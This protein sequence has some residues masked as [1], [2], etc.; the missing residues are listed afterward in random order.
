MK[1]NLITILSLAV[2]FITT[3]CSLD[4][5]LADRVAVGFDD[6]EGM[7][8][9][10]DG[11]YN[12]MSSASY[13]ARNQVLAGEIR[14]DNVFSN[15]NSGRFIRWST[16]NIQDTDSDVNGLMSVAYGS[17][18]N[19]NILINTNLEGI[20]GSDAEKNHVLGE[21]YMARAFV[22]FD[23]LRLFGQKYI[24]EGS[25][26]GVS[27]IKQY[28]G[29][30]DVP[31]GSVESNYED[32]KSDISEAI[33]YFELGQDSGFANNKTNFTLDAAY[34]LQSRI[35]IYM[36]DYPY[37]YAGSSQIVDAYDV[38]P[39]ADFVEMW[40]QQTPPA[41]S[42]FE[43]YQNTSTDN[44]GNSS[45]A[46]IYRGSSY[47]DV[48]A[49]DN[50]LEDAEFEVGNDVRAS[51]DMIDEAN[52]ALRNMGKYPSM[53]QDLGQDNIKVFRIEEVVLN[54]AEALANGAGSGDALEYLNRIPQNRG[55]SDYSEASNENILKERRKE[56]VFE[57]FRFFD[58]ARMG[59]DIRDMGEPVN[60]HGHIEAGNY[61]FA[62]PFPEREIA[63]NNDAVQNPGY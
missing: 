32:L 52:G 21:A 36:K 56:L 51:A 17:L 3:S 50:L 27:Y 31:R 42:I 59:M 2:V 46:F 44:A 16:M 7:R 13:L 18:A 23:L 20:E 24:S 60:N 45:L 12:T 53:G 29:P 25:N 6:A 38:T 33:Y 26:L 63:A 30:K 55:A 37:A 48:V 10:I 14:A 58:L 4:P 47:G 28:K 61:K 35:G 8:Q 34:A 9:M 54:H 22:H 5:T 40:K 49:F 43:I 1:K 19:V 57:G 41:G 11:S 15:G 39:E 62:F